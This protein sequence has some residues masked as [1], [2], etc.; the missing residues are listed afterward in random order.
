MRQ[1]RGH[2][3]A[4][5]KAA[6]RRAGELHHNQRRT[7][8]LRRVVAGQRYRPRKRPA[9]TKPGEK[10]PEAQ[11]GERRSNGAQQRGDAEDRHTGEQQR[12]APNAIADRPGREGAHQDTDARPNER[13]RERRRR[14]VPDM[15][16]GRDSPAY[17]T[18]IVAV[19]HLDQGA[20][21]D[22]ADLQSTDPLVLE[23]SL[24]GRERR[25]RHRLLPPLLCCSVA[26][27]GARRKPRI[28]A[29]LGDWSAGDHIIDGSGPVWRFR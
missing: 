17:R 25:F 1:Q 29:V 14:Q 8:A 26:C 4:A 16:E 7:Q 15:G 19:A 21:R 27:R 13:R 11:Y 9:D 2:R 20:D 23:R 22:D 6:Q 12:F 3:Q 18:H 5:D 10:P 28:V 24:R